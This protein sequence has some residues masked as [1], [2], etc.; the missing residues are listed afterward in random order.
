MYTSCGWFFEEISR[1]E[2]VQ[3]LRYAAR[4]LEL[5]GE[6]AGVDL[7]LEFLNRL[8]QAPSNVE[9]FGNGSE[10]YRQLVAPAQ[11]S[12]QQVAAHYAISSLFNT[13]AR[14]E[15]VY[16]YG[17]EQLDYQKQQLGAL[18]LA[19]GQVRLTS[20]I[21]WESHHFVF[22]VLHLGGW[23]FHCCIQAFA[24]RLAY[25]EQKQQ[26]FEVLKQASAAH[27]I[28]TMNQLFGD[29]SFNLQ[30]LF[31]EER[32]RIAEQLTEQTK[33]HLDQLYTQVYRENYS[34]LL[35]FQ[36][37]ELPVPQELQVAA[38]VALSHRCLQTI[39]VVENEPQAID[40][41][42]AELIAIATEAN[43]LRCR[44]NISE[45][46][47]ILEQLIM[48][49]LWQLLYDSDPHSLEVDVDRINKIIEL[50]EHL[51]LGLF[52]DRTQEIYFN[53]L[54]QQIV[55]SCFSPTEN[56]CRWE[57]QKLRPLLKLGKKLAVDVS[58]WLT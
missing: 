22:A 36:R 6:V 41:H 7:K 44:L 28:V 47:P 21:T 9:L 19:L 11:I 34:I 20:Q 2:G 50:G 51:H 25:S 13:Y 31:A 56:G 8:T 58:S 42:L 46:K 37:E 4:A 5:A 38:E 43:H 10:V 3:I 49:L 40:S 29:C 18:T 27:T 57:R 12:F 39:T 45:A 24:S 1:P 54:H 30:H 15:Q 48:R 32:H 33:K 26:L 17:V 16:C 55:P 35:A 52:L 14:Q 53:C 23:D